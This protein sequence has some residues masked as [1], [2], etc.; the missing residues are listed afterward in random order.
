[1]K[2]LK[3]DSLEEA[4]EKL[5]IEEFR[6]KIKKEIIPLRESVG[7]ILAED[8]VSK[9]MVPDFRRS[10]VD[11]YA[12]RARETMGASE[13]LPVFLDLIGEVNMGEDTDLVLGPGQLIYV[14][15]GGMLPEGSDAMVMVEYCE[16]FD[17]KSI[18]VYSAVAPGQS[19]VNPGDDIKVGDKLISKG[20]KLKAQDIGVLSSMGYTT[21]EVYTPLTITIF[22]SGDEIQE[23]DQELKEGMVYDI[24]TNALYAESLNMGLN[25]IRTKILRDKE[26][27][28]YEGIFHA[29]EYSDIV[30]ISGGSSQGK[31]DMTGEIINKITN[32][33]L[34]THGLAIKPGKPTITAYDRESDSFIIGLPGH[35]VASLLVF[36]LLV[37][38]LQ[39]YYLGLEDDYYIEAE[40]QGTAASDPG[41]LT[42]QMVSLEDS[43]KGIK[44][45][46]IFGKS[47]LM[48][49]LTKSQ[50]YTLIDRNK[51]GLK[52]G[53]KVKVFLL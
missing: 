26:E 15:T 52:V 6:K 16:K 25:V 35:P 49:T 45:W 3:V 19:V 18:A 4:R 9:I 24:N 21:V 39:R 14:P 7:R 23:A 11:G 8:I 17:D 32:N 44:A 31:K 2:L 13:S 40:M 47:G 33:G 20:R 51:E 28:I 50:G 42:C 12:V 27:E 53:E 36:K 37:G 10:T 43:N 30:V 1:M 22:S 34:I 41:K 29:R 48:T 5:V 38:W 46:P